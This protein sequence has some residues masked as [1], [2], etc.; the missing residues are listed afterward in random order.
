[1][2]M[3]KRHTESLACFVVLVSLLLSCF[4][5][6]AEHEVDHRYEIQ[7]FVLDAQRNPRSGVSVS[8]M[9][10]NRFLG[11]AIT[12][13]SGRF[14]IRAHLHD[15]DIG[16]TLELRAGNRRA[17][18]RMQAVRGDDSTRRVHHASFIGDEFIERELDA[19]GVPRWLMVTGGAVALLGAAGLVVLLRTKKA[20]A[21]KLKAKETKKR[22]HG[23][24]KKKK[25]SKR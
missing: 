11:Q 14:H 25:G 15:A 2:N 16:K 24:K 21:K 17:E 20:R 22:K 18:I 6:A 23:K 3:L 13:S 10:G 5:V 19:G 7:G 8:L 4:P 1:M 12:D 9:E